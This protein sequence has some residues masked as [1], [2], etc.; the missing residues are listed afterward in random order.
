MQYCL[1]DMLGVKQQETLFNFFG[2][3]RAVLAKSHIIVEYSK[4]KE[5][6][7]SALALLERDFLISIQ[8]CNVTCMHSIIIL[9]L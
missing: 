7:N 9:L 4:L 3:L 1:L 2:V 8:A 6:L 5:A